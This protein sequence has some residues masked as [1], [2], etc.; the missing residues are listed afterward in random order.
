MMSR[1]GRQGVAVA[2]ATEY[3]ESDDLLVVVWDGVVSGSDWEAFA[4]QRLADD[5]V[6]PR[7]KRRLADLTTF[8][9]SQ[10]S[11][12]DI[13]AVTELFRERTGSIVGTRLA[14]VASSAWEKAREF[15]Q[16]IDRLGSTTIVFNE[17]DGA[18]S[19]LGIDST[20]AREMLAALRRRLRAAQRAE[21]GSP[22][23]SLDT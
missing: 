19:W 10:L 17:V 4:R 14:I 18:C 21:G 16:V 9:P 3:V 2:I 13:E 23:S 11:S 1:A 20:S 22:G 5:P 8:D 7:G 6:W 12:T 15:E